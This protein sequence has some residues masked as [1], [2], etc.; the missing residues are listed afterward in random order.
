MLHKLCSNNIT[1]WRGKT[2][3][4]REKDLSANETQGNNLVSIEFFYE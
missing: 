2:N 1:P 4:E 3:Q